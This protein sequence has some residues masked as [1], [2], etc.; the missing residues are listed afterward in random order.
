MSL[1]VV[2]KAPEY[3]DWSFSIHPKLDAEFG[4]GFET[5]LTA[6]LIGVEDPALL[7]QLGGPLSPSSNAHFVTLEGLAHE[8]GLL[9][10]RQ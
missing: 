8:R 10:P 4:T 6:A 1:Q 5:K 7:E 9:T 2:W 3:A